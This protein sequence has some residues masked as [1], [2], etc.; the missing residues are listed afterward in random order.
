M[1]ILVDK[2]KKRQDIACACKELLIKEGFS[3]ITISKITQTAGISKG[4]FYDYFENKEDLVFEVVSL[5]ITRYNKR[6]Q[7]LMR[8]QTS[9]KEKIKLLTAFFYQDE[10]KELREIYVQFTAISLVEKNEAIAAFQRK[11][12]LFY[13]EWVEDIFKEGISK[14]EIKK[15]ALMLIDGIFAAVK[16]FF[17]SFRVMQEEAKLESEI[18][19]FLDSIF[20]MIEEK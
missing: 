11:N 19:R 2:V 4:S 3:H 5:M 6:I 8:E 16:G 14:G 18:N 20:T 12:H 13:K 7:T 1:A 10:F 15:Q 9:T 17:I